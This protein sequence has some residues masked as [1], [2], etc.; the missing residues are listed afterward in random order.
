MGLRVE[1]K[2]DLICVA[3]LFLA[4]YVF[5]GN[6]FFF[7]RT[8]LPAD[9]LQF[10]LPWG[11]APAA[12]T[13]FHNSLISDAILQSYPWREHSLRSLRQGVVPLWNPYQFSGAP[14]AANAQSGIFYPPAHVVFSIMGVKHG[15]GVAALLH[16]WLAGIG[17][18]LLLRLFGAGRAGAVFGAM[19]FMFSGWFVVWLSRPEFIYTAAWLPFMFLGYCLAVERGRARY[20][21]IGAAAFGM[22]LLAGH[23][24][25]AFYSAMALALLFV[26]QAIFGRAASAPAWK[27]I[28]ASA[29]AFAIIMGLGAGI[30]AVQLSISYE[31]FTLSP[32]LESAGA[33]SGVVMGFA[34][35][36]APYV[37]LVLPDFFGNPAQHNIWKGYSYAETFAYCGIIPVFFAGLALVRPRNAARM[38]FAALAVFSL[39]IAA[40]TPVY[41]LLLHAFPTIGVFSA[42]RFGLLFCFA[43]AMLSGFGVDALARTGQ[44]PARFQG[45][46][47]WICAMLCVVAGIL[48]LSAIGT[49]EAIGWKTLWRMQAHGLIRFLVFMALC[50]AIPAVCVRLGATWAVALSFVLLMCDLLAWGVGF[51]TASDS[52]LVFPRSGF[53]DAVKADHGEPYRFHAFMT[54]S[55]RN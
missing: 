50:A 53:V 38:F 25:M 1:R 11:G 35:S 4:A 10:Q 37:H 31:L 6:V 14:H 21:V 45:S 48:L 32:R 22:Q 44:R 43:M 15:L 19:A 28:S 23:L 46:G 49:Y 34:R 3:A 26:F 24:Q 18:F 13:E 30:G 52:K 27:R 2:K 47:L 42:G 54:G 40:R 51:N 17:V 12:E 5:L 41:G 29:L 8:L 55:V 39:L 16:M 9:V 33:E 36:L 20:A 7:G